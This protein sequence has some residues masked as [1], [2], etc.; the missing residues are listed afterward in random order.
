MRPHE[1]ALGDIP[2]RS[3]MKRLVVAGLLVSAH[4]LSAWACATC[5]C[6]V[7]SDAAMG[8]STAIGWRLNIEYDYIN[9]EQLRS[10]TSTATPEQVVNNPSD[11][12][13]GGGE[14]EQDTLNRYLNVGLSY[15]PSADWNLNLIVPYILRGHSTYGQQQE[16]YTPAES[17]PDQLSYAHVSNLGDARFIVNY[18]GILPT[19]NLGVQLG[20]KVPTG[21][22]GTAVN[23]S[24]GPNAGTPLDTSLQ[25]G[26]G[27]TDLIVGAYY[28]HAVSQNFDAF[29]TGQFQSAF[30]HRLDQAGNDYRPGNSASFSVG[31]RY[32]ADPRWNPQLQLN[33]NHKSADQGA[34]ADVPDT[35]GLV[36]YLSPG[37]TIQAA[38][39]LHLYAVLQL[40]VYSNLSGYQLLPHWTSSAG[41]SYEF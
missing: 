11:P 1:R 37:V 38:E 13:L 14:I 25:A 10:G 3:S 19:H 9:Q 39:K 5:G 21:Q 8:Y 24:T 4:P 41:V 12:A 6:T 33:V 29:A 26:T 36:A 34:L 22:Y 27:S 18:Q 40:P 30:V 15:R 28:F 20:L 32:E 35:A 2:V 23:F 7:N 31:L 16:P 17:A